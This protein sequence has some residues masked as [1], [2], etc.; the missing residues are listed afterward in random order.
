M[1]FFVVPFAQRLTLLAGAG[2]ATPLFVLVAL[3]RL[4]ENQAWHFTSSILL[5]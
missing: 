3:Y 2:I 4:I 5:E 1:M